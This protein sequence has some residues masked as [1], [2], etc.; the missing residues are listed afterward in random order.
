MLTEASQPSRLAVV[1]LVDYDVLRIRIGGDATRAPDGALDVQLS[2]LAPVPIGAGVTHTTRGGYS[3]HHAIK[4]GLRIVGPADQRV[5]A[6]ADNPISVG[7]AEVRLR[8]DY[9][10]DERIHGLGQTW[11]E[12]LDL[13]NTERRIW[14]EVRSGRYPCI[15]GIPFMLSSRGYGLLLNSAF[16]SRFVIGDA[17]LT[18][19]PVLQKQARFAPAPWPIDEPSGEESPTR[20][21]IVADCP[22]IEIYIVLG[23]TPKEILGRYARLTALP[24]RLPDWSLGYIQSRNRYR[25]QAELLALAHEFRRRRVPCDVLVIDWY[26]FPEFGDFDW[27][28]ANWPAPRAM[29]EE[30]HRLGFKVM[31][32]LH[33]YIDDESRHWTSLKDAG[34]LIEYGPA[35]RAVTAHEGLLDVTHPAGRLALMDAV[36]RLLAD[37][38][39]AWWVD[40]T[41][42]E[43]HPVGTVHA[44]GT[45]ER[46]HNVFP[47][48][49]VSAL[50]GGQR[51]AG[52][53]RVC[54]LSFAGY[55][56]SAQYGTVTWSGDVDPTW[57]VLAEQVVLGQQLGISGLPYWT[58]DMGG[59]VHY[60]HYDPELY[61]RWLQWGAFCPLYRTHAKRPEAEP[62]SFGDAMLENVRVAMALRYALVPY[63]VQLMH[64]ASD[65]GTPI[66]RPLFLE[67]P[68]DAPS[69]LCEH[70]FMLG[71]SVLV[72]PV[73]E[74]GMR[75]RVVYMPPGEWF[76]G[77]TSERCAGGASRTVFAPLDRIPYF[78]RAG[79][80]LPFD[81]RP[82]QYIASPKQDY[83]VRVYPGPP[84]SARFTF[85][86]GT[87]YAYE[88]IDDATLSIS[89]D[90]VLTRIRCAFGASTGRHVMPGKLILLLQGQAHDRFV[91][92]EHPA[93]TASPAV[94]TAHDPEHRVL[95]IELTALPADGAFEL[96]IAP[97]ARRLT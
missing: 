88:S 13:R 91:A 48:L 71:E 28:V 47:D 75:S 65:V 81:E 68:D 76:D 92:L 89:H 55:V 59:Y 51:L 31:I 34:A 64:E 56:G 70:Q 43:V 63:L 38:C 8:L 54:T 57:E 73:L 45:R 12:R 50:Y 90:G 69:A 61:V 52:D 23:A 10:D 87:T 4:G 20:I 58:T 77:W 32:S 33:P 29:L 22:A 79:A 93:A 74:A 37:G 94:Q 7:P 5:L 67:F 83:V 66:V 95:R 96:T 17:K 15:T 6:T 36:R 11:M 21:S 82:S 26:W 9:A 97:A 41:Q 85:D 30:L 27:N 60:A 14:H 53:A 84:N 72:A 35:G 39:D 40:Q 16:P 62:W 42:P 18:P 80:I 44:G 1:E 25:N 24:R 19:P 46:V 2:T 49:F 78:V 3:I 86:D